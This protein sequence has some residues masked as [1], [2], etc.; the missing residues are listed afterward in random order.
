M[1]NVGERRSSRLFF[2]F[3]LLE[4]LSLA[5]DIFLRERKIRKIKKKKKEQ[6]G[7][8]GKKLSVIF[9]LRSLSLSL[10]EDPYR[11]KSVFHFVRGSLSFHFSN[12]ISETL[13]NSRCSEK[14]RETQT[15]RWFNKLSNISNL[16]TSCRRDVHFH[17]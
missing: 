9:P 14:P 4:K 11:I 12:E 5:K 10:E 8:K 7:N 17:P 2:F 1:K 6:R 3:F 15:S 13:D 16:L